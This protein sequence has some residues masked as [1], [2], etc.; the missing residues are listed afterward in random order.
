MIVNLLETDHG[1]LCVKE[2]AVNIVPSQ[3][4]EH[5]GRIVKE[6]NYLLLIV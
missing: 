3:S 4:S 1:N 6:V 5:I 2:T